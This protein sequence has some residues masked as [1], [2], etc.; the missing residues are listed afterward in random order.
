MEDEYL[1]ASYED[2]YDLG[3]DY[4]RFEERQLDLDDD[5]DEYDEEWNDE[6]NYY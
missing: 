5:F 4:N 1:D 6:D 3:E 2:R